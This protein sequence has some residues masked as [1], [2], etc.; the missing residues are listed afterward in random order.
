MHRFILEMIRQQ[1]VSSL[2]WQYR[3]YRL[4]RQELEILECNKERCML[5]LSQRSSQ[6]QMKR[7]CMHI[8]RRVHSFLVFR[9]FFLFQNQ[10]NYG[11]CMTLVAVTV[12]ITV[13]TGK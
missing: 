9:F 8:F 13:T 2:A 12:D 3:Q 4:N 6:T 5:H 11:S 10:A 7:Y 1:I